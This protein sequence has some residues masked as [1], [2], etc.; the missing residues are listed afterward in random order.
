MSTPTE[1]PVFT[2]EGERIALGP[3]RRE[4]I[5]LQ[6]RWHNDFA[7]QRTYGA[8]FGYEPVTLEQRAAAYQR[9]ATGDSLWFIIYVRATN[10]PIGQTDLFDLDWRD[11]SARFG[12]MIGEA[13]E[14]GKGYGSE[15]TRLMRDYAFSTLGLRCLLLTVAEYNLAGR[16]AY[17][18]A[19]YR[20]CGRQ[21]QFTWMDGR[22]WDEIFMECLATPAR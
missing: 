11:G 13:E 14:R 3:L 6:A 17:E 2:I 20:E 8:P 10:R 15:V 7:T 9:A 22:W 12:M 18:K 1:P 21:R 4:L 5:P 16:R 19:G